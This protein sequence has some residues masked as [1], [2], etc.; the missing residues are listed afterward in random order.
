MGK[1]IYFTDEEL[2]MLRDAIGFYTQECIDPPY[3][4]IEKSIRD[5]LGKQS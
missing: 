1:Q 4:G 3:I 5:K 2:W